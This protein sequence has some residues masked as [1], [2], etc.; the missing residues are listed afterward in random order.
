MNARR[1]LGFCCAALV[2]LLG[3]V[4]ARAADVPGKFDYWV[5]SLSWSP[6]FCSSN[7]GDEQCRQRLSFVV[8]GLS[9][10]NEDGDGPTRCG[11]HERVPKELMLRMLPLM[12][13]EK[14]IQSEW[15]RDGSCSGLDQ[16]QYFELIERARRKLEIPQVYDAPENRIESSRAEILQTF[17]DLNKPFSNSFALDCRGHWLRTVQVCFNRDLSP[18]ACG[19]K[20][21]ND[22]GSKVLVRSL[23]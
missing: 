4:S 9:T 17:T 3:S 6:E 23:R 15:N 13:T 12:A 7:F 10:Q 18:R 14:A 22:C 20:I 2:A 5:L 8:D 1:A 21:E 16:Q 11:K 19:E